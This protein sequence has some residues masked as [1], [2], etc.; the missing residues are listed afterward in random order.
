MTL[1]D[2]IEKKSK[3]IQTDSYSMS[4]GELIN[5]YKDNELQVQP[6]FQRFFRWNDNQKT[7]LI[8]SILLG[9]PIP[10]IFVAQGEG[11]IW[12][13]IDGLQRLSTILEFVGVLKNEDGILEPPNVLEKTKFLPS[14]EGKMWNNP[15]EAEN[16][17]TSEQRIDFKRAKL[18]INIIKRN[19]DADAKYELFQRLNTGG[20]A[21]S[22]QEIRNCLM[23]MLDKEFYEWVASLKEDENFKA[24]LPLTEKQAS[25]QEYMEYVIRFLVYRYCDVNK[26]NVQDDIGE[27][28]TETMIEIIENSSFDRE[29]EEKVFK[30]TFSYLNSLLADDVFKK[31][32]I[33]KRKF[34]GPLLI[35]SF[36]LLI[37]SISDKLE[38]IKAKPNADVIEI[39]KGIY[40]KEEFAQAT[41]PGTKP[42]N[43][44]RKMV[45]FGGKI[46]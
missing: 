37:T 2:E 1:K 38:H 17:F 11:G 8:E 6:D 46:F 26:I 29:L 3:E 22:P 34:V 13:V 45:D 16:S 27:Y 31:Y 39:L 9:I 32:D 15:E 30:E 28:L 7:R 44:F 5:M 18:D 24:C 14:L 33:N 25:Q 19:S 43:R 36:E 23:I 20:T 4:I 35:G 10:P 42:L 40:E 21:L 41:R 12:D